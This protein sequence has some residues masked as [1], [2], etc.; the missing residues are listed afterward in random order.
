MHDTQEKAVITGV[1]AG[2]N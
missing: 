2:H 1:E